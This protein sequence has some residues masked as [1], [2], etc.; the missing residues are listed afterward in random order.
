MTTPGGTQQGE[1]PVQ[2]TGGGE[3]DEQPAAEGA[4]VAEE[5]VAKWIV[6]SALLPGHD[7]DRRIGFGG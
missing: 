7:G 6:G 1:Q 4:G 5:R 3:E 2:A